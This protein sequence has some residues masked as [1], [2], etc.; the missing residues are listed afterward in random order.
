MDKKVTIFDIQRGSFVDGPG[1]RTTVFFKGCNLSCAW[2]HNPESQNGRIQRMW[3]ESKCV[4]CGKCAAV[5]P[6]KAVSFEN[7]ELSLDSTACRLCGKCALFCQVDAISICGRE[8]TVD[9]IFSEIVK[10]KTFYESSGGGVTFSG[11]ECMLHPDVIAE[12]CE[13]CRSAGINTAIDTAGCVPWA[14]FEK[15]VGLADIFLYDIKCVTPELSREFIGV[16]NSLI[17]DNYKKLLERGCEVIVRVPMI[18]EC[19]ANDAEFSKI[20][21][22]LRSNRPAKVELL[23]YHALGENKFRA[24]GRG[25]PRRFTAPAAE[26]LAGYR[27][28]VK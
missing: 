4:K 21:E 8:V 12:L 6:E 24:L 17:L 11:G 27:E 7:G 26:A 5:C 18:V 16:D 14:S 10:D 9:E 2:C 13:K 19:S 28:L 23:P 20:A 22:F 3:Y 15:V 25:E 1:I